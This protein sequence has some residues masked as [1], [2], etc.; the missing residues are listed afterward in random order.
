MDRDSWLKIIDNFTKL[1]GASAMNPQFL[2][3]DGHN[4]HWD[5]DALDMM[6]E[7]NVIPFS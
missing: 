6:V 2:F 7:R 3:F 5:A 4:S 1:S